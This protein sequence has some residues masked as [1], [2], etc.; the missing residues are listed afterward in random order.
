MAR[1]AGSLSTSLG[2]N[3]GAALIIRA[4]DHLAEMLISESEGVRQAA[5]LMKRGA[6][7]GLMRFAQGHACAEFALLW[8]SAQAYQLYQRL[9]LL[10][11]HNGLR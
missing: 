4:L 6:A 2:G 9:N 5:E 7:Y 1:E 10:C 3:R 8:Y 11:L